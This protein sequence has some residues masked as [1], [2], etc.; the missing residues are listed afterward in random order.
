V[1]DFVHILSEGVI[2]KSGGPELA[3]EVEK[4]GYAGM[5]NAA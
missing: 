1:P 4:N 5:I 2:I 3:L